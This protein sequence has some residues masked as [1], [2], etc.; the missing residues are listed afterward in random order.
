MPKLDNGLPSIVYAQASPRSIG[1]T[2]L[3][4][5][6]AVTARTAQSVRSVFR[7]VEQAAQQLREAGF[8][9]F[10][11]AV[12]ARGGSAELAPEPTL[13]ISGPPDLYERAFR[14]SSC[15]PTGPCAHRTTPAVSPA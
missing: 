4:E 11:D 8:T 15:R 6:D 2:S 1:G 12:R 14:C 10:R 5:A 9:V 3:F 7:I 13:N